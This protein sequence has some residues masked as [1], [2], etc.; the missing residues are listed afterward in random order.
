MNGNALQDLYWLSNLVCLKS[1]I[2]LCW[3]KIILKANA[4]IL[5]RSLPRILLRSREYS[6]LLE[7]G[8]LA[9][10]QILFCY[11]FTVT[12]GKYSISLSPNSLICKMDSLL[13]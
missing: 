12:L 11:I 13:P 3:S 5:L 9:E 1:W 7:A 4:R 8:S 6:L 10:A 2:P